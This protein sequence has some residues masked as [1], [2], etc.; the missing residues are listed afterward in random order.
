MIIDSK[1]LS[2]RETHYTQ[3]DG[4]NILVPAEGRIAFDSTEDLRFT[5]PLDII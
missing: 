3:K 2:T 5:Y 4:I 1:N